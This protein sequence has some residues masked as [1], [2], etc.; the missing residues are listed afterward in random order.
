MKAKLIN[1]LLNKQSVPLR[2]QVSLKLWL[3]FTLKLDGSKCNVNSNQSFNKCAPVGEWTVWI[4]E[5]TVQ[6]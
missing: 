5:C 3:Q 2:E 4:P 6:R 1:I